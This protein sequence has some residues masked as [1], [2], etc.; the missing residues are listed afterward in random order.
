[1]QFGQIAAR[2][3]WEKTA[4][5]YFSDDFNQEKSKCKLQILKKKFKF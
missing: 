1:M 3:L 4:R 5:K 2:T